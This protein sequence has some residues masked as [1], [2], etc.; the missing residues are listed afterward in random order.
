MQPSFPFASV[1]HCAQE[2]L[3]LTERALEIVAA[4]AET[5]YAAPFHPSHERHLQVLELKL[6][7]CPS[8]L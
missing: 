5:V 3:L 7:S 1:F 6:Q 2:L 8:K 4:S